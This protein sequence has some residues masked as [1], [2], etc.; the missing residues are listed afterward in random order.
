[1][2]NMYNMYNTCL[3]AHRKELSLNFKN[4][5]KKFQQLFF[6]IQDSLIALRLSAALCE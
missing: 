6:V 1:M 5:R 4:N 2:Y 3:K